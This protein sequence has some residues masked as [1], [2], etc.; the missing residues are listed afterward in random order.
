MHTEQA[1]TRDAITTAYR[2]VRPNIRRTPLG[3]L[4]ED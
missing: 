4:V 1:I 2:L 3:N